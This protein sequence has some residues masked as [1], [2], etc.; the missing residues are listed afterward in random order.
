MPSDQKF[1]DGTRE[2]RERRENVVESVE[3]IFRKLWHSLDNYA[4]A[5]DADDG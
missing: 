2:R 4:G 3:F 5:A 1:A